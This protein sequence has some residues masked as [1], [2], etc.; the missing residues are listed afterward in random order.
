MT[1]T[2]GHF[3]LSRSQ[4]KFAALLESQ[5]LLAPFWDFE[6]R[7]CRVAEL[8]ERKGSM[9]HGER[10]LANFFMD[11]WF[12]DDEHRFDLMEAMMILDDKG[13]G[14]VRKWVNDPFFP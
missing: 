5:P 6:K 11:V 12:R 1:V 10:V 14:V 2:K 9:S 13:R 3:E 8:E 7:E 4:V